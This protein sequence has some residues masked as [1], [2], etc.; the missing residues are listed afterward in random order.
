MRV[1][2]RVFSGSVTGSMPI[3][4]SGRSASRSQVTRGPSPWERSSGSAPPAARPTAS[5]TDRKVCRVNGSKPDTVEMAGT[6]RLS[7]WLGEM[8]NSGAAGYT[9][10]AQRVE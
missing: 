5:T 9:E 2:S 8:M 10:A 4:M 6:L 7:C 1:P 3:S